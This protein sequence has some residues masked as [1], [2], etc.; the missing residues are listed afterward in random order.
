MKRF[1]SYS[2]PHRN[3]MKNLYLQEL[4]AYKPLKV[5]TKVDLPE[6]FTTPKAPA[7]PVLEKLV[8]ES[9]GEK[10]VETES[11]P[12]LV[13]PIDDPENY[14]G[15]FELLKIK[16]NGILRPLQTMDLGFLKE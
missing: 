4:K 5:S 3:I 7:V 6:T 15:I 2:L 14:N 10:A 9:K 8:L 16:M 12:A 13:D 1:L 11:W